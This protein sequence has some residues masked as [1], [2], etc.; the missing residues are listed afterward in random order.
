MVRIARLGAI[1]AVAGAIGLGVAAPAAQ[2]TPANFGQ[3]VYQCASVM[4]PYYLNADGSISMTMPDGTPMYFRT[5][6]AMVNYMSA[7]PMCM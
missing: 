7:V 6:G 2:A 3:R 5:F 4:L 1:F